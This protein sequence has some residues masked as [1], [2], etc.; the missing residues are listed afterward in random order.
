MGAY[1]PGRRAGDGKPEVLLLA[2]GSEV[3]L[4]IGAY[5]QLRAE[6]I[7]A[8]VVSMPSW[9]IFEHPGA[10]ARTTVHT[11]C[12]PRSPPVSR[13]SKPRP[14]A[15]SGTSGPKG[16][17]I[18]MHTFGAS[19]PLKALLQKFGFTPDH[20]VAAAKQQVAQAR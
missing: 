1:V 3:S 19:A 5:E 2:T 9:E 18:G 11:Y 10:R 20:V 7:K 6:G 16:Q 12:L 14:L 17:I 8:R 4:C 15:G 13:W